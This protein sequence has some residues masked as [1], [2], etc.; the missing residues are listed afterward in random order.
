MKLMFGV[1]THVEQDGF[2]FS[3]RL[4]QFINTNQRFQKVKRVLQEGRSK[5]MKKYSSVLFALEDDSDSD[6]ED[7]EDSEDSASTTRSTTPPS[8]TPRK[9]KLDPPSGKE[10]KNALSA[11]KNA[12]KPVPPSYGK[13]PKT[14]Q[15][16]T[17]H[18]EGV[19]PS[20]IEI[21]DLISPIQRTRKSKRTPTSKK[22]TLDVTPFKVLLCHW[23]IIHASLSCHWTVICKSLIS[24]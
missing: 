21:V 24:Y 6:T 11:K 1:L 22:K 4:K 23:T 2:T 5:Y 9:Q 18:F 10:P 8:P 17:P 15:P 19:D 20:T 12:K 7:S 13:E 3:S 16:K 14:P